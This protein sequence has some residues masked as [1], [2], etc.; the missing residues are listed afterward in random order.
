MEQFH[1]RGTHIEIADTCFECDER[2]YRHV[3]RSDGMSNGNWKKSV[4]SDQP[5]HVNDK[6]QMEMVA[7]TAARSFRIRQ[8]VVVV[9]SS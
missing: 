7:G 4:S 5:H 2:S 9:L 8:L 1:G 3:E 6:K